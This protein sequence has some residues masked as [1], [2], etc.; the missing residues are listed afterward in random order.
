[1]FFIFVQEAAYIDDFSIRHFPPS[2]CA[3]LNSLAVFAVADN[4]RK[5]R[6]RLEGQIGQEGQLVLGLPPVLVPHRLLWGLGHQLD[7]FHLF[8]GHLFCQPVQVGREVLVVQLGRSLESLGQARL[9]VQRHP[10]GQRVL[11]I[12]MVLEIQGCLCLHS[13]QALRV[14]PLDRAV[15]FGLA[16][17]GIRV[18]QEGK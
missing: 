9:E 18:V 3:Q 7:C 6:V 13:F 5:N 4:G 15:L 12:P 14:A 2:S 8:L 17:L 1:M 11:A 16:I 10:G